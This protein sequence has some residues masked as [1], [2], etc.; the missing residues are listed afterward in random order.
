MK[1]YY[2]EKCCGQTTLIV[3]RVFK[4]LVLNSSSE[5]EQLPD[6]VSHKLQ[7]VNLMRSISELQWFL[8]VLPVSWFAAICH[9]CSRC[10]SSEKILRLYH[11]YEVYDQRNMAARDQ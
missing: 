8:I 6:Y 2:L 7:L 5:P 10:L 11:V 9:M 1:Q 3:S 4:R